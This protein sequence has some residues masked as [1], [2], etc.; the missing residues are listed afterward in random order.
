[1]GIEPDIATS[2]KALANGLPIGAC[3]ARED[4]AAAFQPGDHGST[5]GGG[6]V[7]CAAALAVLD[8][9]DERHLLKNCQER[10]T[11]LVAGLEV[12]NEVKQVRGRGLLLA[13][14]LD[15][16]NAGPVAARALELG[17]VV[18][19]VR[20]DAIRLT[21]PLTLSEEEAVVGLSLLEEAIS[22][23]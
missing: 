11:Q 4:V 14:Q 7:V 16:A 15:Q 12:I 19:A 3:L 18:N 10:S 21:P 8:E 22:D 20:S 5:F 23:A 6:P 9:V 1:M 17:L 13:A 2:A